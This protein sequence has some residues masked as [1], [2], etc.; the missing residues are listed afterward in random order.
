MKQQSFYKWCIQLS[1]L[2]L[3]APV[4]GNAI[5]T[6]LSAGSRFSD[7]ARRTNTDT[8]SERQD[9]Y[10][11]NL[12]GDYSNS[13]I[14]FDTSYRAT[15][16]RFSKDSQPDRSLVEGDAELLIGKQHHFVDL[17]LSHSRR[18]L[19]TAPDQV[20]LLEN[21][22]EREIFSAIPTLRWRMSPVDSLLLRGDITDIDY[23]YSSQFNSERKGGS[24]IWQHQLSAIDLI[25]VNAQHT[26]IKYNALPDSDYEFQSALV[27]YSTALRQISYLVGLGYNISKPETG[28]EFAAP[29]YRAELDYR[30]GFNTVG[31]YL[32]QRITDTSLG[33]GNRG[34]LTNTNLG[35]ANSVGIDQ[36]ESQ[37]A[38]VRWQN[39]GLCGRC[40]AYISLL[41]QADDYHILNEDNEQN[42]VSLSFDYRLSNS[43]SLGAVI[44][45]SDRRFDEG[46]PR[47][48]FGVTSASIEYRHTFANDLGLRIFAAVDEGQ[49][50]TEV[51]RYQ[52]RVSGVSVNYTF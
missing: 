2:L 12:I 22:D 17:M 29:S 42:V 27:T 46:V 36:F 49:S 13:L 25:E 50:D 37:V 5:E 51:L 41:Y 15:E 28:D 3:A 1:L 52:E 8:I 10:G 31:I 44:R 4:F 39:Q 26:D 23:R 6:Q 7:N 16:N 32:S 48:D 14:A 18:S 38:E 35:D 45:R 47:N 19:Q 24:L 33:N 9:V 40:S 20:N 30:S 34:D 21:A 11:L 43:A